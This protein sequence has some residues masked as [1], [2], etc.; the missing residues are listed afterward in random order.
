[1][2]TMYSTSWCGYCHRLKSQLDR[3]GIGYEVIDI[4]APGR[5]G[6]RD[7]RQRRQPDRAD[8]ALR[9]RLGADQPDHRPG[10][11][12]PAPSRARSPWPVDG[13]H[14]APRLA[15]ARVG[16][17]GVVESSQFMIRKWAIEDGLAMREAG[18]RVAG[19][20]GPDLGAG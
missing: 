10:Q 9:R 2:L 8:R 7:E 14:D 11:A 15:L 3:E 19:G 12:A 18:V 13:T 5:G 16:C 4:E 6:V 17:S 20:G 1:M